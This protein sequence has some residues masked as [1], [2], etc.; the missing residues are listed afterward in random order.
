MSNTHK[1]W[2]YTVNWPP[3]DCAGHGC[4]DSSPSHSLL[5]CYRTFFLLF[6][7]DLLSLSLSF[8]LSVSLSL[9]EYNPHLSPLLSENGPSFRGSKKEERKTDRG[10]EIASEGSRERVDDPRKEGKRERSPR[11][12]VARVGDKLIVDVRHAPLPQA[13]RP[14]DQQTEWHPHPDQL[15]PTVDTLPR[16]EL[17]DQRGR[18]VT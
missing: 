2:S 5:L 6:Y 16:L 11:G 4:F 13:N 3:L 17:N 7:H 10:K 14:T 9:T 15:P 1:P 18:S 12:K 8:S